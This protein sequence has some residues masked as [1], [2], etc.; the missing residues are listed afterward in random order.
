MSLTT[1]T[2]L[3][4]FPGPLTQWLS[5]NGNDRC[6]EPSRKSES[7][8]DRVMMGSQPVLALPTAKAATSKAVPVR[9]Y[10]SFCR[11]NLG[12]AQVSSSTVL[13]FPGREACLPPDSAG[14]TSLRTDRW[15]R[16]PRPQLTCPPARACA[17][18]PVCCCWASGG[19]LPWGYCLC[20]LCS[21]A[22]WGGGAAWAVLVCSQ[23]LELQAGHCL[24]TGHGH[25]P[26]LHTP[27]PVECSCSCLVHQHTSSSACQKSQT[28]PTQENLVGVLF[29]G[30]HT[31]WWCSGGHHWEMN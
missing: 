5:W 13:N 28:D 12:S 2:A 31:W 6:S 15:G 10:S 22:I 16:M 17:T 3:S 20:C 1:M 30:G 26:P 18:W 4:G 29:V 24:C 21:D 14:F 11:Q 27:R 7:V 23:P 8:H 25:L 9:M 19:G